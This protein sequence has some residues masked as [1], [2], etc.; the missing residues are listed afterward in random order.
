MMCS[1]S[2]A[3]LPTADQYQGW[4]SVLKYTLMAVLGPRAVEEEQIVS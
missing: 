3:K 1:V 2:K 4:V